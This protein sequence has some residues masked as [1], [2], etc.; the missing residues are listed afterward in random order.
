MT[1]TARPRP[2]RRLRWILPAVLVILWLAVGGFGGP[3]AG[4]LSTVQQ[5][6]STSFL[7]AS[8]EATEVSALQKGFT[9][10]QFVPAIVVAERTSGITAADTEFLAGTANSFAG[11]EGFGDEVSPPIPSAD[12]RALQMFVPVD[13]AG[14][15]GDSVTELRDALGAA[16]D[17]LTV[18]VT[19]P[20][21]QVA[22][23]SAAFAGIDGLLLLVAGVVVI[24]ILIVVYRS[25]ILPFAVI[26]SA[27]FAL[28]LSSLLVYLL[29]DAGV[30]ALN[31]QSQGILFILVF[32]AA[33]DYAL[34]LVSRYREELRIEQD[35]YRAMRTAWRATLEPVAASAGTV[36]AGVLC[37]LLS[38]LNSNRGLGPVAAI[39]IAAS[40]V[41]SMTY[42]PA[43]LVL[44]GRTAYWPRRP[45]FDARHAEKD[46]AAD[47]K[48]W[49]AL[50]ARI[51]AHPR[52]FWVASSLVLV[53]FA[54]LMP[55]FEASGVAE[56]ETFLL[57]VD[58]VAGQQ[59]L[60]DHFDAGSGSPAVIIANE[61]SREAVVDAARV[62]GVG[63]IT[64]LSAPG[65]QAPLV[66][67][68]RVAI[69]ATLT[70]PADSLAA[71][72]TIVRLREAVHPIDGADALVGGT[73]AT[74]LDTKTTSTRDRTLIIPVVILVVFAIL[75]LLLRSLLA[76]LLL[77]GTVV[78]SFAATL[79]IS[80]LV[81]EHIFG[82]PGADPVVPLFAFVFLVALG[83]DYNIFL[84][85]RVRE[86]ARRIGTRR[87]ALRGLTVTGGV[88]TSAG[89]VLAA[90]F[91][92]LAVI[93][94]IFLAQIAFIVAFGVLL[95]ALLV[96]SLLVPALTVDIGQKIW[97]PSKLESA[98][99]PDENVCAE[100]ELDSSRT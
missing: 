1:T 5:N 8:A 31:G 37:L 65:T 45:A 53:L 47:H 95:D 70:D 20:A 29:A 84:M 81:F 89:V 51:G 67:D 86:E 58:S 27:V 15:V 42:L 30:I 14:E 98:P 11:S 78:L 12:G 82:F 16:P 23:L 87:G 59:I 24:L 7:P 50:A 4:K 63:D 71:E 22:D 57:D 80:S 48:F 75:C 90:T 64:V 77:M 18:L 25:P 94:L 9:D 68:G 44:L 41:A 88:I 21:G 73:T 19:G 100:P 13:S 99:D 74:D 17:G 2:V 76:P 36:I 55:Q 92:A 97:W 43:L 10:T 3:F 26:T 62:D 60:G 6:D 52:R 79:G 69:E 54:L 49:A 46:E 93:P 38:D 34:L 96:R 66:V 83:I 33:T 35:K 28:G 61:G 39:G 56:S 32:G 91:S 85:T 40:F 72:D